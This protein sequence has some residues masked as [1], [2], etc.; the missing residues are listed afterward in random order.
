MAFAALGAAEVALH[1]PRH[2]RARSLLADAVSAIGPVATEADWP[3]PEPRLSYANAALPEALIAAGDALGRPEVTEDGLM[4]LRWLLDRET[5]DG[6]LSPTA[7]GGAGR[8]D[9]SPRFDQQP[10]EVAAV[11]DACA[12]AQAVTGDDAWR[13][14]VDLAIGWFAGNNDCG[15]VMWDPET[16]G[17]YDGLTATGPNLN[18]GAES[19]LALISTLQHAPPAGDGEARIASLSRPNWSAG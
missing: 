6:H 14:G 15:A 8:G 4:L 1:D 7:V 13:R 16:S 17:G 3:W 10:I 19:T 2:F 12:R 18:Q 11:A 9:H 5:L